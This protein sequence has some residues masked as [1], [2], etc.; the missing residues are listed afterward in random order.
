MLIAARFPVLFKINVNLLVL[1]TSCTIGDIIYA[2]FMDNTSQGNERGS[3]EGRPSLSA[4]VV[5]IKGNTTR[6]PLSG[7]VKMPSIPVLPYF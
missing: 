1:N 5:S 3:R 7:A 6:M 4:C 2:S